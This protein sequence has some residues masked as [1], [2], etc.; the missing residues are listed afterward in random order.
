MGNQPNGYR[1]TF[2][3]GFSSLA[4]L[5]YAHPSDSYPTR[6]SWLKYICW[7]RMRQGLH[8]HSWIDEMM[9]KSSQL[10]RQIP[11]TRRQLLHGNPSNQVKERFLITRNRQALS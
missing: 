1:G 2:G 4:Q 3:I 11:E 7:V 8:H 5:Q 10:A 9:S 6:R